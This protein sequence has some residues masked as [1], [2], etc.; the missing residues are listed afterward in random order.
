MSLKWLEQFVGP[1]ENEIQ[2]YF[3]LETANFR[4]KFFHRQAIVKLFFVQK[5]LY[6]NLVFRINCKLPYE[7]LTFFRGEL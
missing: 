3:F 6:L 7:E 2:N 4:I 5:H 1:I